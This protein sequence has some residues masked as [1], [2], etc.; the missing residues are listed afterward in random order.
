MRA[1][2][3][4]VPLAEKIA[5]DF[6]DFLNTFHSYQ[7]PWDDKLDVWLHECYAEILKD[8]KRPDFKGLPYFS[9]STANSC[10][11]EL[12]EKIKGGER[13]KFSVQPHQ[14][15][16]ASQGTVI[17]DWLQREILL[18][19]K[20]YKKFT[21]QEPKFKMARTEEGYPYFEDFVKTVKEVEHN[22]EQF[23]LFGTCD[24]ILEYTTDTGE[25]MRVGLEIKSKQT[26]YAQTGDYSMR[27]PQEDHIKQVTC[28]SIM[29]DVD[30]YLIVYV[31]T[32][33]KSWVM[34]KQEAQKY[35]DIRVFGVEVTVEMK[36]EILT[37]FAGIVKA[38]NEDKPPELDLERWTFNNFKTTCANS[39]TDQEYNDIKK[40]V[41]QVLKSGLPDWHKQRY[42]DAFDFIKEV[43]KGDRK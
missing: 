31:N 10:P 8:S 24:G 21:G 30:Y 43:R 42:L 1:D 38:V 39:L 17:G 25:T 20:H 22:G 33:K 41:Q 40:Q 34:T 7:E 29:Y 11:R 32:S 13:D 26:T 14:R 35:P 19:E 37:Y 18:A 2:I 36:N 3:R 27:K 4:P 5:E 12:Y 16:W 28:Y 9:P 23:M 15:R 6:T